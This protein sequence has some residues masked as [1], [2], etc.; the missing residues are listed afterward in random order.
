MQ[1]GCWLLCIGQRS[2][3]SL[4]L[5]Y[6]HKFKVYRLC[7]LNFFIYLRAVTLIPTEREN[8]IASILGCKEGSLPPSYSVFLDFYIYFICCKCRIGQ[9]FL[10][11]FHILQNSCHSPCD[12]SN[13]CM[14]TLPKE[15]HALNSG[16]LQ[17]M[18]FLEIVLLLC[19]PFLFH[20]LLAC[21]SFFIL[22]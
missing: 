19:A 6:E 3:S 21:I 18:S 12:L 4:F 17:E 5:R 14:C 9:V 10:V 11:Y 13:V 2:L 20:F 16:C 22:S 15:L 1:I 7:Y 8:I